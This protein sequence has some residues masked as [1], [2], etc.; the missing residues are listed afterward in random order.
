M[1]VKISFSQKEAE[2]IEFLEGRL[3]MNSPEDVIRYLVRRAGISFKFQGRE[4]ISQDVNHA[5]QP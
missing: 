1:E 5:D 2:L 4:A 3:F